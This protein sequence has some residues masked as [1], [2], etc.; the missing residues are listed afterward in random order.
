MRWPR[1]AT[2]WPMREFSRH[3][4]CKPHRWHVQEAGSGPLVLLIH[5]AG[6][7]TQSYRHLFPILAQSYHVIAIDLPGQGFTQ[8]GGHRRCGL[9]AMAE[10]LLR[11]IHHLDL[12]PDLIV[13][14]SAGVPLALCLTELGLRPQYGIVGINAALGNFKGVAGWLFPA[15]AKL[16]AATPFTAELFCATTTPSSVHKLI[17]GTGSKLGPED[18]DLYLRLARDKGHVG[19][20]LSMMAQW[21]LDELL[22][23][24]SDIDITTTFIVGENDKAVPPQTSHDAAEKM[25]KA[26]VISL[27]SLGHLAHEEDPQI[28]AQIIGKQTGRHGFP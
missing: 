16:L 24:L 21:S 27:K 13:G 18:E 28:I 7:A 9:D 1:D 25:P 19:A 20:T 12:K 8:L 17:T 26:Q 10:D 15:M 14:H 5:G 2:N 23:R 3:V 22:G 6:G 11:L 4:L